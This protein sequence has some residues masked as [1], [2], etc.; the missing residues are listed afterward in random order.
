MEHRS[1]LPKGVYHP[2]SYAKSWE[3]HINA[4]IPDRI[5]NY[6]DKAAANV[7]DIRS[8]SDNQLTRA[9]CIEEGDIVRL[10]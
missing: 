5:T 10:L 4:A 2:L 1:T 3:Y 7:A 6:H 8:E 9:F